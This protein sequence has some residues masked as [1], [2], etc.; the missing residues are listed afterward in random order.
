MPADSDIIFMF[1][2]SGAKSA[3]SVSKEELTRLQKAHID[4]LK[5]LYAAGVSP[6]AGPLADPEKK[7]RGIVLLR[8]KR[9]EDMPE[10]FRPDPYVRDGFMNTE[11]HRMSISLL[12]I[13]R[14]AETGISEHTI[15]LIE[16]TEG[17]GGG[18]PRE[19]PDLMRLEKLPAAQ[20]PR[21][22]LRRADPKDR[23]FAVAVF[24]SS[25]TDEVQALLQQ[26]RLLRSGGGR[27]GAWRV[28]V[29]QQ[30][31]GKDALKA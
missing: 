3:Q 14:P 5:R 24:A 12:E 18:D 26:D 13:G 2:T 16:S 1:F 20:R 15:A 19:T 30:W 25:K 21:I 28:H 11:P 22:L 4:N 23:L 8:L 31:L 29:W 27:G 7:K 6:L 9:L 10:Q 17:G